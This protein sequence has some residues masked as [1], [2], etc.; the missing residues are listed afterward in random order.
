MVGHDA[1]TGKD[2]WA[3]YWHNFVGGPNAV[4]HLTHRPLGHAL[5]GGG[6]AGEAGGEVTNMQ[7]D[8]RPSQEGKRQS[9]AWDHWTYANFS[10]T[11]ACESFS[12]N[13]GVVSQF[14]EFNATGNV[15]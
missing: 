14:E 4:L 5:S 13:F 6:V 8:G 10:G 3:I 15:P 1:T 2:D 12:V 7:A 11:A 9:G